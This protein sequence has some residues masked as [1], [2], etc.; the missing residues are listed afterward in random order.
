MALA[1]PPSPTPTP[2]LQ[3]APLRLPWDP[4]LRPEPLAQVCQANPK[5]V[6]EL[7]SDGSLIA[8]LPTGGETGNHN[9]Y[10]RIQLGIALRCCQPSL[11]I[12]DSSTG[13]RLPDESV[14]S[15]TTSLVLEVRWQA[16]TSEQRRSFPPLCP[17]LVVELA[18]PNG[19]SAS[20]EGARSVGALRRTM[21]LCQA[22]GARLGWLLLAQEQTVEIWRGRQRGRAARLEHLS[23]LDGGALAEELVVDLGE[24]W[25]V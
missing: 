12:F 13:F 25:A 18:N 8:M 14:L 23:Q 16:L 5:A 17:D 9:S 10:L 4:R 11:R 2:E 3:P 24:I 21:D 19:A 1:P 6:L 20:D 22:N 7:A 15:P